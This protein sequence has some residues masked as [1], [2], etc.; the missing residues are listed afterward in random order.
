MAM[1]HEMKARYPAPSSV[2][3]RM[4]SDKDFHTR[5]LE[6]LGLLKYQVLE[7]QFDG[8]EFRIK[9]ERKVPVEAPGM[10]KKVVPLETTV[11]NEECWSVASKT[12]RVLVQAQGMPLEMSCSTAMTDEG[13]ECVITYHWDINATLPLVGATL[14]KFVVADMERRAAEETQVG[15][16]LLQAY[17]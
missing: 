10:V 3:I 6:A 12:G 8:Q 4:F 2:V 15:I 9:I 13:Q 17:R 1:K 7:H 11:V 16:S 5:K 14:E